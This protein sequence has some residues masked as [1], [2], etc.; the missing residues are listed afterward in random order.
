MME[1]DIV[2]RLVRFIPC[3]NEKLMKLTLRL[4]WNLS[5]DRTLRKQMIQARLIPELVKLLT[6][7]QFRAIGI[8]LLYH[9]SIMN[10]Q[11][12]GIMSLTD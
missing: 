2:A 3:N 10:V 4:L 9:M 8:K 12:H 11:Y 1:T 7:T 5:F 6:F